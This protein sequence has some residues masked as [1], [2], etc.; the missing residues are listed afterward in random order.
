MRTIGGKFGTQQ[1]DPE[2]FGPMTRAIRLVGTH[3]FFHRTFF[4][5]RGVIHLA[6]HRASPLM[7]T[8]SLISSL[9]SLLL[10]RFALGTLLLTAGACDTGSDWRDDEGGDVDSSSGGLD[11][12]DEGSSEDGELEDESLFPLAAEPSAQQTNTVMNIVGDGS[13]VGRCL[14]AFNRGRAY[15]AASAAANDNAVWQCAVLSHPSQGWVQSSW[16]EQVSYERRGTR[17][18]AS[19]LRDYTCT[20]Y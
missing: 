15:A 7:A 16:V 9:P 14:T 1:D 6:D 17:C 19:L 3:G 18:H 11:F 5:R 8:S 20:P 2:A 4:C 13:V 12:E 10:S